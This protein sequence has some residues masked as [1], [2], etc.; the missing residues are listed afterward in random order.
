MQ[1]VKRE[2]IVVVNDGTVEESIAWNNY[3]DEFSLTT[4]ENAWPGDVLVYDVRTENLSP[5]PLQAALN[6]QQELGRTDLT[7]KLMLGDLVKRGIIRPAIYVVPI[8][9][10]SVRIPRGDF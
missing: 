6:E 2:D 10:P 5:L 9:E 4:A 3:L 8:P 7:V 1:K